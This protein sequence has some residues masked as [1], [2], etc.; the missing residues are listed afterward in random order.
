MSCLLIVGTTS[1]AQS[2]ECKPAK[3][4]RSF[5]RNNLQID[6]ASGGVHLVQRLPEYRPKFRNCGPEC[7]P[8]SIILS[9]QAAQ[10]PRVGVRLSRANCPHNQNCA[11]RYAVAEDSSWGKWR[12]EAADV[13][14]ETS[15]ASR[16][17]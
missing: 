3:T 15:N 4:N 7:R 10:P 16:S 14:K 17:D 6:L 11:P 9:S 13:T 5:Q 12:E 8:R 2:F 1:S